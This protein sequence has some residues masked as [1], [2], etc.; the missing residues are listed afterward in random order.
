MYLLNRR[1]RHEIEMRMREDNLERIEVEEMRG[2][3]DQNVLY[4]CLKFSK[5]KSKSCMY[6]T[7]FTLLS[8]DEHLS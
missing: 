1:K 3:Y 8:T 7:L 2:G 5:K 6:I 4:S